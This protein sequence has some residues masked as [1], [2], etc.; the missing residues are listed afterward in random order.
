MNWGNSFCCRCSSNSSNGITFIIINNTFIIYKRGFFYRI[1]VWYRGYTFFTTISYYFLINWIRIYNSCCNNWCWVF[2]A[3]RCFVSYFCWD[4]I[5]FN[6]CGYS[7]TYRFCLRY[8]NFLRSC[9][10]WIVI[11]SF[12]SPLS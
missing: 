10:N 11:D 2:K 8:N 9:Y 3:W 4:F 5:C 6:N 7:L 1:T 12:F